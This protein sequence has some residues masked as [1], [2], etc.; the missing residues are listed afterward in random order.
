MHIFHIANDYPGS[1]VYSQLIKELDNF[2]V[3]QTVF[4]T[5][6]RREDKG[7]NNFDFRCKGSKVYYSDNWRPIHRISFRTKT[8]S[9]YKNLIKY[10]DL[11][12]ITHTHAHTLF[13]DGILALKLYKDFGIPYT[14]T[15]RNTDI[16]L[17]MRYMFHTWKIG[18]EVMQHAKNIVIVSPKYIDRV[19]KWSCCPVIKYN[20]KVVNIPNGVD[21]FWLQNINCSLRDVP[22]KDESWKMI[23]VGNFNPGKNVTKLMNVVLELVREDKIPLQMH[24]VGGGGKDEMKVRQIAQEHPTIFHLHGVVKEKEKLLKLYRQAHLFTMPSLAETF[25]L[26]YIEALTQGLPILYTQGEGVDGFFDARYGASCNP[27]SEDSIKN[28]LLGMILQFNTFEIDPNYLQSTFS[29]S[30]VAEKYLAIMK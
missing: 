24:L 2:G 30:N 4:T 10:I 12:S 23:Y 28:T 20:K 5:I 9:N 19:K 15:I 7:K 29:W 26:V 16:N 13:S 6:R 25:G 21:N 14:V 8:K 11:T 18:K 1:K 27:H 17:Y 3:K 22:K